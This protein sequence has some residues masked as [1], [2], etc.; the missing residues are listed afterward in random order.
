MKNGNEI[1]ESE[2]N[3]P[4]YSKSYWED[5]YSSNTENLNQLDE[6]Y[7]E[8]T[9]YQSKAFNIN[10]WNKNSEIILLGA[11]NS[12]TNEY[13]I[14]SKFLHV[15]LIDFSQSLINWLKRSY[16]HL[17]QCKEWDCKHY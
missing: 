7:I 4:F 8:L 14:S 16:E 15:T 13:L 11:G 1:Q 12:K 10:K 9:S 2:F 17:E 6:W 5:Y 3:T